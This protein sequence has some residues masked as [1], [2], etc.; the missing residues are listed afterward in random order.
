M[1]SPSQV[2][3]TSCR[4]YIS[5]YIVLT[6]VCTC[7][8]VEYA[9]AYLVGNIIYWALY[10]EYLQIEYLHVVIQPHPFLLHSLMILYTPLLLFYGL[11]YSSNTSPYA[12]L[13]LVLSAPHLLL[14]YLLCSSS[15]PPILHLLLLL[16]SSPTLK[17]LSTSPPC[18]LSSPPLKL[19]ICYHHLQIKSPH[20]FPHPPSYPPSHVLFIPSPQSHIYKMVSFVTFLLSHMTGRGRLLPVVLHNS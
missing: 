5:T 13:L 12:P 18:P 14:L 1:T 11:F 4:M 19:S 20:P 3:S 17:L 2:C 8:Y 9:Y 10:F 16:S 7:R 6:Y 15:L